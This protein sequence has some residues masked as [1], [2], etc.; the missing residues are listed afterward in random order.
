M[1]KFY[2]LEKGADRA[3]TMLAIHREF[4]R[5][6]EGTTR[7][8]VAVNTRY[9]LYTLMDALTWLGAK[10]V[11]G[12]NPKE[13]TDWDAVQEEFPKDYIVILRK[14]EQE[15]IVISHTCRLYTRVSP[16]KLS[17][18]ESGKLLPPKGPEITIQQGDKV[19]YSS[20]TQGETIDTYIGKGVVLYA[21]EF[22]IIIMGDG[23]YGVARTYLLGSST[24][25]TNKDTG[26]IVLA[27]TS[28]TDDGI[29]MVAIQV[30]DTKY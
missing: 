11:S 21:D 16:E 14:K 17:Y 20:I 30:K 13:R 18:M 24:Y 28:M 8:Y 10:W 3:Y 26:E 15:G 2:D 9:D 12:R 23:D 25:S 5:E 22:K 1:S 6:V 27:S 29:E 7:M 19:E 4:G